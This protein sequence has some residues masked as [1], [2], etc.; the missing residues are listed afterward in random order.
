[1]W[2]LSGGIVGA[3]AM[4]SATNSVRHCSASSI[5]KVSEL[6]DPRQRRYVDALRNVILSSPATGSKVH[7]IAAGLEAILGQDVD[8]S[9][10]G[11]TKLSQAL[12]YL[13]DDYY[14]VNRDTLVRCEWSS[15]LR[16]VR[17]AIPLEGVLLSSFVRHIAHVSPGFEDHSI[18]G[19]TLERWVELKWNHLFTVVPHPTR[20]AFTIF[21]RVEVER[22]KKVR[23]IERALTLLGRD[24]SLPVFT[25]VERLVPLLPHRSNTQSWPTQMLTKGDIADAFDLD[26]DVAIRLPS[27]P[28]FSLFIDGS[29]VSPIEVR[30]AVTMCDDSGLQAAF[31]NFALSVTSP[32][33]EETETASRDEE[34]EFQQ[35]ALRYRHN[36]AHSAATD[37]VVDS[38]MRI[39]DEIAAA[40]ASNASKGDITFVVIVGDAAAS[41]IAELLRD[42]LPEAVTNRILIC[43]PSRKLKPSSV[44]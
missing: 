44:A 2:R 8:P 30:R 11:F 24:P 38:F 32:A 13:Q 19:F 1:M 27:L 33:T 28:R 16:K 22:S 37:V 26:V 20:R 34:P 7:E 3:L 12:S 42:S 9:K 5:R 14:V 43:T 15:V 23:Q 18:P 4:R 29:T 10:F 25:N 35:A 31:D 39:S 41:G 6:V 17:L 36:A 40:I 21:R